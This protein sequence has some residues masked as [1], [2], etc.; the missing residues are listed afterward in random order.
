MKS[1]LFTAAAVALLAV[2]FPQAALARSG[3]SG[4]S[5]GG[6]STVETGT[7]LSFTF[8]STIGGSLPAWSGTY[9]ITH[10]IP[11]YYTWDTVQMS[12]KAKPC[13][14]PDG[15]LLNVSIFTHDAITGL[16]LPVINAPKVSVKSKLGS[17]K[18]QIDILNPPAVSYDRVLDQV[19]V[20]A[21][22]G[23]VVAVCD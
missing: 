1:K 12:L 14:L 7:P 16:A 10:S 9:T 23:T 20:W 13:N 17:T 11:G 15:S 21:P 2:A 6:G 8:A 4:G 22:D 5:G 19:V 3:G 18:F